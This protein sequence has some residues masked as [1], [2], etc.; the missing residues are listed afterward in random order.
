MLILVV[1]IF[2]LLNVLFLEEMEKRFLAF[3]RK[4]KSPKE[5]LVRGTESAFFASAKNPGEKPEQSSGLFLHHKSI[6]L[7]KNPEDKAPVPAEL[8]D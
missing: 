6:L 8:G 3:L 7:C 1:F 5:K 4:A 2:S